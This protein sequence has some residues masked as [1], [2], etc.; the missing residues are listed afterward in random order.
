MARAEADEDGDGILDDEDDK[1]EEDS[2]PAPCLPPVGFHFA[3]SPPP[4]EALEPKNPA[5][6]MLVGEFVLYNWPS[7]G[8]CVGIVREANTDR[9]FKMDGEVIKFRI[10]YEIDD[11]T[12]LH[13]LSLATYGGDTVHS[14]VLLEADA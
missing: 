7:V 4:A 13:V 5:Q 14:W 11:D 1:D 6:E 3:A 2:P 8:W 12:S 10:H 9:R